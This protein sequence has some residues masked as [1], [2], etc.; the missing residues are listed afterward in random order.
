MKLALVLSLCALIVPT[1][2]YADEICYRDHIDFIIVD[3][4]EPEPAG[5]SIF[6]T[7]TLVSV[8]A[9]LHQERDPQKPAYD[10]LT[11]RLAQTLRAPE[12]SGVGLEISVIPLGGRGVGANLF[13]DLLRL[14]K[15]RVHADGGV[16]WNITPLSARHVNRSYDFVFGFGAEIAL[17]DNWSFIFDVRAF[18]PE[19]GV[20]VR[21][22]DYA[23]NIYQRAIDSAQCWFGLARGW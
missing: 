4:P 21:Y 11:L 12:Y 3:C 19:S 15:F 17:Q 5:P 16:F 20:I 13:V 1:A 14:T 18:L 2:S 10:A 9:P 23:I 7:K 8:G 22:G 6:E